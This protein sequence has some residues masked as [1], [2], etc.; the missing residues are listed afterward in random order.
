MKTFIF[1][2]LLLFSTISTAQLFNIDHLAASD[3]G[4]AFVGGAGDFDQDGDQDLFT[5]TS[6]LVVW[7]ENLDGL[8]TFA[9]LN[10]I[11][12]GMGQSFNQT[13]IDLDADGREDILISY[14]DQDFIAYYRNLGNGH[15]A[16]FQA[17]AS[18]LNRASGIAPG[19]LDGDGDLDLVLGVSNGVGFYWIEQLASGSFG[20]LIPINNTLSQARNQ[21]VADIDGDG[22]LDILTN[23]IS[24]SALMSWF[25]NVDGQGDFSEQHIIE[26]SGLYE[27]YFQLADLDGDGD[28]DNI[29]E[30]EGSVLWRE[31]LD[32]LG[33]FGTSQILF[34]SSDGSTLPSIHA[35]DIDNDGDIDIT[36]DS[37]FVHGKVYL[38]NNGDATFSTN[39]VD[40]PEGGTTGNNIA[41]L[42]IDGDE[43]LDLI[44]TSLLID[45]G[46]R[47]DLYW[48]ENL[49]ILGT[50]EF[51]I[52]G[53]KIY[54]NPAKYLLFI[55]SLEAIESVTIYNLLGKRLLQK[56][57]NTKQTDV[58]SLPSGLL[59][60]EVKTNTGTIVKKLLKGL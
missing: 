40:P 53:L 34:S 15:F 10:T 1:L 16:P 56:D 50:Q 43:D 28:L 47:N 6:Q 45:E 35:A 27:P 20:S 17:L 38:L 46:N 12:T 29:T 7:Y 37:G 48:Y 49:T 58:F 4:Y 54:P 57:E 24:S 18:G 44:S 59:F 26:N 51:A 39:F 52:K 19:D 33:T 36:F 41:P 14:F 2:G 30:K 25:E 11:D 5:V 42:D 60:V 3:I 32:G 55:T 21:V 23:S 9:A 8:G 31:N 22:D 13:V